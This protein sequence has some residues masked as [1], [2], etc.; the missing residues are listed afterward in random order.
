[1]M[2]GRRR[3]VFCGGG[4]SSCAVGQP[5]PQFVIPWSQTA[6]IVTCV[7]VNYY[8]LVSGFFYTPR[9][10][11]KCAAAVGNLQ[12]FFVCLCLCVCI[13][14]S[15]RVLE[16]GVSLQR[17]F[18]REDVVQVRR[19]TGLSRRK[20]RVGLWWVLL[21]KMHVC[22]THFIVSMC[23]TVLVQGNWLDM[24]GSI[25]R[26]WS[27]KTCFGVSARGVCQQSSWHFWALG[28]NWLARLLA[29]SSRVP[30]C[31]VHKLVC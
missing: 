16:L 28:V 19:R 4:S 24:F 25:V 18:L 1:M 22:N 13:H 8:C 7:S 31:S 5:C 14:R 3:G 2:W 23:S 20:W 21:E 15:S 26:G 10:A 12:F 29:G 30:I 27:S 6:T 17:Q 9:L 11:K